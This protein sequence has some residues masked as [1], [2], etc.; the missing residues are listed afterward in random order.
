[1]LSAGAGRMLLLG[2]T[3]AGFVAGAATTIAVLY[4]T[5]RLE[6]R[7]SEPPTWVDTGSWEDTRSYPAFR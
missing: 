6:R 3:L 1:M 5:G 4:L 2:G 7:A